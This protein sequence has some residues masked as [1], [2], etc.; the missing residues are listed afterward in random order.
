MDL[1][2]NS[3]GRQAHSA[4]GC[5]CRRVPYRNNVLEQDHRFVKVRVVA[6]Q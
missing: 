1:E 2:S 4:D 6:I 3:S 5:R